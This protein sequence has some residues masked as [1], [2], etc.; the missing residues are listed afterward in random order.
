MKRIFFFFFFLLSLS[1]KM[2]ASRVSLA[3][4][5][6]KLDADGSHLSAEV[7]FRALR[8]AS[9]SC[10][11]KDALIHLPSCASESEL[12]QI[13]LLL[14]IFQ[15]HAPEIASALLLLAASNCASWDLAL[16]HIVTLMDSYEFPFLTKIISSCN[17]IGVDSGQSICKLAAFYFKSQNQQELDSL[18]QL[19]KQFDLQHQLV[20]DL[21][22]NDALG[23][24]VQ[25]QPSSEWFVGLE[26]LLKEDNRGRA[27]LFVGAHVYTLLKKSKDHALS[28][29]VLVPHGRRMILNLVMHRETSFRQQGKI[30]SQSFLDW[31][32]LIA[33]AIRVVGSQALREQEDF[34]NTSYLARYLPMLDH[35]IRSASRSN[36]DGDDDDGNNDDDNADDLQRFDEPTIVAALSAMHSINMVVGQNSM[37][38]RD[39]VRFMLKHQPEL[40][41]QI[42]QED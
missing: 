36:L 29:I 9:A 12:I 39:N 18:L 1:K 23:D 4:F 28:L 27:A 41:R 8:T 34:L 3:D 16:A 33:A 5:A 13:A 31:L 21:L 24:F 40:T 26:A 32:E 14:P 6:L 37:Q 38:T 30:H 22:S 10:F 17:D 19:I 35:I 15:E 42:M 2:F 11:G 7:L 20:A 25:Q